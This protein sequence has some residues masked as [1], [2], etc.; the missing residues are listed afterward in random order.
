MK[1][2]FSFI[3]KSLLYI[4]LILF[5]ILVVFFIYTYVYS[6]KN[7][8]SITNT[9]AD[10][11]SIGTELVDFTFT[12][13][14][15]IDITTGI[16]D[17]SPTTTTPSTQTPSTNSK[18]YFY[19]Q[20]DNNSKIIYKSLEK[21]MDNLKKDNYT[22]DFEN[23]FDDLL[24]EA[25]GQYKL[26]KAF[27][28]ALD[29]FF[30]DHPELFYIDLSKISLNITCASLGPIQK[31][32]VKLAPK[33]NKNYLNDN[34]YSTQDAE[35]AIRKVEKIKNNFISEFQDC[36]DY[37]KVLNVH[38][39]LADA[40]EYESTLSKPHIHNIYGALVNNSVVCEGYAKAL[41][42]ILDALNIETILVSGQATNSSGE[43]ESHMWNY[44]RLNGE[45]YGVDVTW[46]DPI[47][48]GGSNRN[49]VRHDYFLKGFNTFVRTHSPS[50]KLSN[51]GMIFDFPT[52]A[53]KNYTK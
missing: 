8:V 2:F 3:F 11:K 22:I 10:F 36:N 5:V 25:S 40:L 39:A 27:Q 44:V 13:K 4:F 35:L 6:Q 14:D 50:G 20:L 15:S 12:S 30:Y 37:E 31:Y 7:N 34:F 41:K 32:N 49:N 18:K 47:I 24:H 42:Y 53:N 19:N 28:S 9:L 38:N 23:T 52:L 16:E 26:N 46:D 1:K 45:W 43:T 33:N 51:N 17:I 29:A 48:I 21:H